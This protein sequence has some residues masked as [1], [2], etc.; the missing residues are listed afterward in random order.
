MFTLLHHSGLKM[1]AKT[2]VVRCADSFEHMLLQLFELGDL[3]VEFLLE[4]PALRIEIHFELTSS[5]LSCQNSPHQMDP[6]A[7]IGRSAENPA[8]EK[9]G[10]APTSAYEPHTHS[11]EKG[12]RSR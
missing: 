6:S 4:L 8:S 1:S 9:M 7:K 10:I 5:L 3:Y 11:H 12:D 2:T